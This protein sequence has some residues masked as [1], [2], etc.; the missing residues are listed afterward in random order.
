MGVPVTRRRSRSRK[1]AYGAWV[2][3]A[4]IVLVAAYL[5]ALDNSRPHVTGDA[6][7][8]SAFVR[9]ADQGRIK[10]AQVLE[11]DSYIVGQYSKS[12]AGGGY[13]TGVSAG[14]SA[15][16]A[17][18]NAGVSTYNTPFLK[19]SGPDVVTLLLGDQIPT[20]IDQQSWK[21]VVSL[22]TY[23]LPTLIVVLLL[24]Y[25][26][27]AYRRGAGIFGIRS[28]AQRIKPDDSR[29]TF[30]DVAGQ[31]AA[32]TEL[33]EV[34]EFLREPQR[35]A[36][37]GAR[38]PKGILMYGPPGCGKT[39]LAKAL[40]GEA[41]ASFY[42]ISGSDF[43]EVYVG[44]G[45]A[46]VRDLFS[47][48]RQHTPAIVFV[49]EIDAVGRAR[50]GSGSPGSNA[51]Q[52]QALNAILTEMDGFA[53]AEGL[54]VIGATNRPDV[55]DPA[56]LRPGRFDRTVGLER[57]DGAGRLEILML[58]ARGKVLGDGVDLHDIART[59]VGLTGADLAS[60]L[61]EGALLAARA[62]R[63]AITQHDLTDALHRVIEAPERQRRLSMRQGG[64]GRRASAQDRVSFADVAGMDDAIAELSEVRDYLADPERFS[65]LGARVPRGIL[66]SGPPGCGKTLLARAVAGEANAAFFSAAATEFVE[67]YVGQGAAR[68]REIFAQ[69]RAVPPAIVFLDE[70]DAIGGQRASAQATGQREVEQTLNQILVEMDGFESRGG[71]IVMAATNRPDMLDAALIRPGRFDRRVAI[72]PP[73]REGR[74]AILA[75]HARDKPL[76][77]E[78]DLDQVARRTPGFTGAD[79]ANVLNEAALLAARQ[80]MSET[81]MPLIV[82]AIERS[83]MGVASSAHILSERERRRVAV[84]ESA[85][86]L[87]SHVLPAGSAVR[88]VSI[89]RRGHSLGVTWRDFDE[90]RVTTSRPEL[91]DQLQ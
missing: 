67:V 66:L 53:T 46:R 84:H 23:L 80:G 39:L 1:T 69:A 16:Q 57:P 30:A 11:F 8:F 79:L 50:A 90:D 51:E 86:A 89:I 19:L 55:L 56:L 58:H 62:R 41:G 28:G 29:V 25:L 45:A 35:Y 54:I 49:D 71:L 37:L 77:A 88:K 83:V 44:V 36:T 91:I 34:V 15:R 38:I 48:A 3:I 52:E 4:L 21:Q 59:A 13:N 24:V 74:R 76:A 22:A 81:P 31:Q 17:A 12:A 47:V 40:A 33:G 10:N 20:T 18:D 73:N 27:L 72:E 7:S 87:V 61:N 70:L 32:I 43:V 26:I 65:R 78:V 2:L 14:G 9:L 42:S 60:L 63:P 64:I 68:V 85:H 82:E 6:V 75:I 5:A